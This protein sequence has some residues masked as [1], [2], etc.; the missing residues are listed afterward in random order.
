MPLGQKLKVNKTPTNVSPFDLETYDNHL[1]ALCNNPICIISDQA[2]PVVSLLHSS[3]IDC[4]L[5]QEVW[6]IFDPATEGYR[7]TVL[8]FILL[9]KVVSMAQQRY[10]DLTQYEGQLLNHQVTVAT[11]WNFVVP[12]H[13]RMLN[14][15]PSVT[16]K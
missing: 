5:L 6:N 10:L 7:L 3:G 16:A 13:H 11:F 4:A 1:I 2:N 12:T 9:L 8:Q 14:M 15:C